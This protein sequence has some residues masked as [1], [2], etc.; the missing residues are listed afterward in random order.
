MKKEVVETTDKKWNPVTGCTKVSEGCKHCYAE[1]IAKW[2]VGMG[3]PNYVDG[4][5]VVRLHPDKLGEP[6]RWRRSRIVFVCSMGDLFHD[7]VPA[8]Y[9]H[10]VFEVMR[11]ADKQI[12]VVLTKRSERMRQMQIDWPRNVWAG[13]T[14]ENQRRRTR[15]DDLLA[16]NATVKYL[17]VEPL[18]EEVDLAPWL[19][20]LQWIVLGGESGPGSRPMNPE[21]VRKVRDDCIAANVPFYFKQWGGNRRKNQGNELD[22]RTWYQ[23]PKGVTLP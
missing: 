1:R 6:L 16:T 15:I 10:K 8:D 9:I 18:L 7:A 4:F 22:G 5:E 19:D 3:L 11:K 2:T 23:Y 20:R 21:W 17:C 13:V 14:V 12:F